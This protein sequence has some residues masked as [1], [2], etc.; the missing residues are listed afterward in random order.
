MSAAWFLLVFTLYREDDDH[1]YEGG[2]IIARSCAIAEQYLRA[3][4][5]A[6]QSLLLSRC[7]PYS[8]EVAAR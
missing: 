7:V 5:Q 2:H 3:G 8:A 1:A 6:G 4:L